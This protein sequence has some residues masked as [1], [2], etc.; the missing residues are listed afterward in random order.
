ML[1]SIDSLKDKT[2]DWF[3]NLTAVKAPV[4]GG[5]ML[6]GSSSFI[7][8][9]T[10]NSSGYDAVASGKDSGITVNNYEFGV[11]L[12]ALNALVILI[13]WWLIYRFIFRWNY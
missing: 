5:R 2:T 1:S 4:E 6:L 12:M 3:K 13:L 11:M 8:T 9:S 7:V 10:S